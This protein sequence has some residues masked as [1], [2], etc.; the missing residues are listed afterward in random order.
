MPKRKLRN[1]F[2]I[3]VIIALVL[4]SIGITLILST[5]KTQTPSPTTNL[6]TTLPSQPTAVTL[7]PAID[8]YKDKEVLLFVD[9]T[10][11]EQLKDRLERYKTDVKADIGADVIIYSND[12]NSPSQIRNIIK[13]H[14]YTGNLLGSVLVGEIPFVYIKYNGV[15][16]LSDWYYQD[17]DGNFVDVNNSGI[18][19]SRQ[20]YGFGITYE[21]RRE[22]SSSRIIP[23]VNG[24][25]GITLL[26]NYFDKNHQYRQGNLNYSGIFYFNSILI[27]QDNLPI[28]EYVN[29]FSALSSELGLKDSTNVFY[30]NNLSSQKNS[31]LNELGKP[32]KLA[33]MNIHGTSDQEWLGDS[34]YLTSKDIKNSK[35]NALFVILTSCSNGAFDM[36][37]YLAGIYLFYGNSFVTEG[38]T[39]ETLVV[40]GDQPRYLD[41][42]KTLPSGLIIGEVY[43]HNSGFLVDH[44]FGDP[45]L[46]LVS[47][48]SL[49]KVWPTTVLST[50]SV[51]LGDVGLNEVK[52]FTITITNSGNS[53]LSVGFS[54]ADF[55]LDGKPINGDYGLP[56]TEIGSD[57]QGFVGFSLQP[58]QSKNIFIVFTPVNV[59]KIGIYKARFNYMTNDPKNPYISIDVLADVTGSP[60]EYICTDSDGGIN[61]TVKGSVTKGSSGAYDCCKQI[62]GGP[63][64]DSAP[65]LSEA[66]CNNDIATAIL[67]SC[68]NGCSNGVCN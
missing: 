68:S 9:N 3:I 61:F 39:T 38:F 65:Y 57:Y 52:N 35:S 13:V 45:T 63:C 41:Y 8:R 31:I 50:S 15:D 21:N 18:V 30:G 54:G 48:E 66:Y 60:I 51:N 12:W 55:S 58:R 11:Y 4:S 33:I 25:E 34:V 27:N 44:I 46:R 29:R 14:Y 23:P 6:T 64:L 32:Y 17:M 43:L 59:N 5:Q 36:P 1:F 53:Q 7:N 20:D 10:T 19:F 24:Q 62:E 22:V 49:P 67:Y 2:V 56:F 28:S 42:L 47:I 40:G 16:T 37:N 26:E